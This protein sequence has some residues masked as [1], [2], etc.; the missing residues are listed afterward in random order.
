M[1]QKSDGKVYQFLHK[2]KLLLFA[3]SLSEYLLRE[4]D[5]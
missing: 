3:D 1:V 4:N 5:A 2:H